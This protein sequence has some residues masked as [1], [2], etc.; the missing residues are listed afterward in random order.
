MSTLYMRSKWTK[1]KVM[2]SFADLRQHLPETRRLT[3]S[4]FGRMIARYGDIIVKPADGSR[5]AG[6]IRIT[7]AGQGAYTIHIENNVKTVKGKD[8]AYNYVRI[9]AKSGSQIVQRRIPLATVGGC[10][11]DVRA[12]VQ[13]RSISDSW[14]VTGKVAKVAGKGYFVTNQKRSKGMV[15]PVETAIQKSSLKHYSQA[16]LL[17][18]INRVAL[19]SASR[20]GNRK[21]YSRQC[22][23]GFDMGLAKNG[24][25]WIIEANLKPLLSHFRKL[26]DQ[27]MYR[28][29]LKYKKG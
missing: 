2:R 1:H 27:T 29:I 19:L 21:V 22:I 11:F 13:R 15:L 14:R 9:I 4:A 24:H 12:I 20:L 10:P 25:V 3:S 16:T 18:A 28:R 6:V 17:S 5:G 7:A 26:K 8:S 23:F